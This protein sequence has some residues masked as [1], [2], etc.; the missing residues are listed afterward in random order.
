MIAGR[1][2]R[3]HAGIAAKVGLNKNAGETTMTGTGRIDVH[4]HVLPEFYIEA[5]RDAGIT[6]SAYR[7]F[8]EWSPEHSLSVM[9]TEKIAT[10]ILSF[11]SPG[12]WFGDIEQTKALAR[13]CN[14]FLAGLAVDHPGQFGGFAFLPLPDIDA[15]LAETARVLD[16]LKLDGITL[17]TSVDDK[18]IGHPE[19]EPLYAELNRRKAVVFIHPCYPPGTEADGWSIPRM[20]IDYPFETT[21]VAVNLIFNGV[22]E[23][24]PDIKFI[25]S[26]SGGTLPFLA[27][28]VAI[29]DKSTPFQDNYPDGALA[30]VKRFWFDTALSGD[31]VP[32]AGLTGVADP[33]RILFGTDYPY[34]S[35]NVVTAETDGFDAW[36]GFT[37]TQRAGVNRGNAEVLFPRFG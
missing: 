7:G 18:Y 32:L 12:I 34:I 14:D 26:H 20:L 36:D 13:Q 15:A 37:E 16:D 24:Y 5:Q 10:S 29:F 19:F 22:T 11:T 23:R 33:S 3:R 31:A 9:E 35:P 8:P 1:G 2:S 6:G 30:Y 25:L 28:R 17:L 27:H 4:H 21:R